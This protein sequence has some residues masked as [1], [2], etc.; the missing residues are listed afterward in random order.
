M[1]TILSNDPYQLLGSHLLVIVFSTVDK[2]PLKGVFLEKYVKHIFSNILDFFGISDFL[3]ELKKLFLEWD[4]FWINYA[5]CAS[6]LSYVELWI[7][8][9]ASETDC[10]RS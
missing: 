7:K 9:K 1:V 5:H 3:N 6:H 8:V 4:T 10:L 2:N